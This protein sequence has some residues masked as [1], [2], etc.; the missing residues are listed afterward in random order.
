V[1]ASLVCQQ[2]ARFLQNDLALWPLFRPLPVP[3]RTV[4][5]ADLA[6]PAVLATLLAWLALL[7]G[8]VS[9]APGLTPWAA[10]VAPGVALALGAAGAVDVLRTATSQYLLAG[11]A[12]SPGGVSL[13]LAAG[14]LA[15][16]VLAAGW[17]ASHGML[18]SLACFTTLLLS[19]LAAWS[20]LDI[21][22]HQL[23]GIK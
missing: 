11:Q 10:L 12:A 3:A 18:L 19:L 15:G 1:W 2:S 16:L 14:L 4:L 7:A 5:M 8:A 21:A 9:G 20:L 23:K 6:L 22:Q 17:L 13:A